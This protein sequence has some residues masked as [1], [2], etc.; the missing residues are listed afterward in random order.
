MS[1]ILSEILLNVPQ[2]ET[3]M[4]FSVTMIVVIVLT[5]SLERKL[6]THG[7]LSVI[8]QIAKPFGDQIVP[9]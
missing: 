7:F 5:Q 6:Q 3:M 1:F 2:Q 9:F 8:N 4:K